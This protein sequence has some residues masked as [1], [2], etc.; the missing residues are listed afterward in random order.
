MPSHTLLPLTHPFFL[1]GPLTGACLRCSI[2]PPL[3]L[4]SRAQGPF[5]TRQ[6][7]VTSPGLCGFP[8]PQAV[9]IYLR[10]PPGWPHIPSPSPVQPPW[11]G[12]RYGVCLLSSELQSLPPPVSNFRHLWPFKD[13]RLTSN[14]VREP[15]SA[16]LG[17][18]ACGPGASESGSPG[19]RGR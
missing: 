6:W 4:S 17:G 11:E 1:S 7:K 19:E 13:L 18:G 14:Q 3:P 2:S 10:T 15:R 8:W 12:R 16:C 9:C 5:V